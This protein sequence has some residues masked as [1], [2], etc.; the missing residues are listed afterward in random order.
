MRLIIFLCIIML[1]TNA[2]IADSPERASNTPVAGITPIA[3]NTEQAVNT[4]QINP[5]PLITLKARVTCPQTPPSRLIIQDRGR[6]SDSND[7]TLNLRNG[8]STSFDVLLTLEPLAQFIV[9]AGPT[10]AD[11][12]TW[13]RVRYFGTI[14]WIAEGDA[15]EYYV[16]PYLTG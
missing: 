10:C 6:V 8:P 5:T 4:A 2:C 14:G 16:E 9:I 11:G 7:E 1:I 12:F 3:R 13:F 15:E